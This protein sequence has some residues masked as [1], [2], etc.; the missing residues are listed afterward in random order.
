MKT[1]KIKFITIIAACIFVFPFVFFIIWVLYNL[2][3][4][5]SVTFKNNSA[6]N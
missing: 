5:L 4:T 3:V 1:D 6:Q 2:K